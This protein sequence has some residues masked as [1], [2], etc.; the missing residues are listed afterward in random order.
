MF[1]DFFI[2]LKM[3]YNDK[4]LSYLY[5]FCILILFK[6]STTHEI[7]KDQRQRI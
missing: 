7:G 1:S 6:K 3:K 5:Y 2:C 4:H